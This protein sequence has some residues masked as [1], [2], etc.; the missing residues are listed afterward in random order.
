M[1]EQVS[2]KPQAGASERPTDAERPYRAW[3]GPPLLAGGEYQDGSVLAN[4]LGLQFM[5]I[6]TL[7]M[8]WRLRKRPV[9]ADIREWVEAFRRDGV[10][11]IE[12]FFPQD[13]F[14]AVRAECREAY[15]SGAF[16][17]EVAED[18][19]IIEEHLAARGHNVPLTQQVFNEHE[20]FK[21][22]VAAVTR[23]PAVDTLKIDVNFMTKSKDAPAPKRM[24]GTNYL[25]ADVHY[26]SGKA[27]LYLNDIDESNGAF[28]YAKGSKRMTLARLAHEYDASVRHAKAKRDKTLFSETPACLVRMPTERQLRGMKIEETVISGKAN[29]L[30]FADVMG[31]H[32]RGEFEEGC[33]REQVQI[34]FMDRPKKHKNKNKSKGKG[35][36]RR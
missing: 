16:K 32:K 33:R 26:S 8:I 34:R 25:H 31:F 13:V 17:A 14:E 30:V 27:W 22:L 19:H 35:N 7:N 29:T 5:R 15:A 23:R 12:N 4:R 10:L 6:A 36:R 11:V 9:D 21:R 2:V 24:V 3:F 20:L 1:S 28:V 18:N